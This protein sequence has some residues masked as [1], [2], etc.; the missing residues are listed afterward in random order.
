MNADV[1]L[2]A[3]GLRGKRIVV[4]GGTGFIGGRLV[5]QLVNDYAIRPIVLVRSKPRDGRLRRMGA[6]VELANAAI[7]DQAAV[8]AERIHMSDEWNEI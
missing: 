4:T 1:A 5:E 8:S 2:I 6:A 7:T 3:A